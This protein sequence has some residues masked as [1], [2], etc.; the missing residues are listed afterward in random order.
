MK[1]S[2]VLLLTVVSSLISCSIFAQDKGKCYDEN[3][4]LINVGIGFGGFAYY[5]LTKGGNYESGRTPVFVLSYEQPL[6][7]KVGPGYIGLG[8]YFSFQNQHERYNYD[9]FYN[10]GTHRYYY[11]HNW[12]YMTIA[13]RG[14]YHWD[15]LNSAKAEVYGGS[16]IGVR[17]NVYNYDSNN[18]DPNYRDKDKLSEA[19]VDA[20]FSIFAGARWY[21]APNVALYAE[22]GSGISF[23][24]GG[25][26]FKF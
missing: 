9:Y 21:F 7:N 8:P 24:S 13:A 11:E 14:T 5:K 22:V 18:P 26:T 15:I 2:L 25:L 17:I 3:S 10:N 6:K 12:N 4:H 16:M 23:L 19:G 20:A 1:K